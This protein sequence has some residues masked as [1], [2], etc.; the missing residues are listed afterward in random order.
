VDEGR[1]ATVLV[2]F[3]RTLTADFSIQTI[4]D[5]LVRRVAEVIPVDGA[6]VLLMKGDTAHH[7]VAASDEVILRIESLQ[8][9]LDEGP[10]LQ[11]YQTGLRVRV[12][13]LRVDT[14]FPRFSKGALEA[15]LGAVYSFPLRLDSGRLGALELYAKDP[16]VLSEKDLEGAQT[17]ADVTA[18]YLFNAQARA[19]AR[20]TA[21][22]LHEKTLHDDLTG[23]PNRVLLE[24]R[25]ELAVTKSGRSRTFAGLLFLDLDRFKAVNDAF[26]HHVGDELL[27]AVVERIRKLLRPGDTLA[28]LSGDE[29]VVLCEGL[30][31]ASQA[32]EVAE[33]IIKGLAP[34]FA[35]SG[36]RIGMTASVGIAFAG[37]GHDTASHALIH[38]DAAMYQAKAHGGARHATTTRPAARLHRRDE[39]GQDLAAALAEDGLHLDYQPII[40]IRTSAWAGVEALLRWD[41]PAL[42]G[43][44]P[45]AVLEAAEAAGLTLELAGWVLNRACRD[46]RRWQQEQLAP[47]PMIAVNVSIRELMHPG[48]AAVVTQVLNESQLAPNMLYL[49]IT[50]SILLEDDGGAQRALTALR[51]LGATLALDDF[52]TGYSSLNHLKR[53]P[54]SMVKIDRSFVANLGRDPIDEAIVTAVV[55]LA[56]ALDLT[57]VAEGVETQEQLAR[58]RALGCE[59]F[60]GF[61]YSPAV[62]V[63]ALGALM[64]AQP[65][66]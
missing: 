43:L 34:A 41:H 40:D 8:I 18:A 52:G 19:Q 46:L 30:S 37:Y 15:G 48:Y 5:H 57:V 16:V 54:V 12:P 63:A 64:S 42:G 31:A 27:L 61:V 56:H 14:I 39:L 32:E 24:D 20:D 35:I 62:S 33:R 65:R 2:D 7:F 11:A 23:L 1:L 26:G 3:A 44:A 4:L 36:H 22:I 29:F 17:L 60:Q 13:D 45:V 21:K 51:A 28:R 9:N 38:A 59:N 50:E 66:P 58:V 53:F 47:P 10:C 49:E 25:L 6:G 55:E